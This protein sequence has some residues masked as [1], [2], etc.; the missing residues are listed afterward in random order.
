MADQVTAGDFNQRQM[1]NP[2]GFLYLVGTLDAGGY[3]VF[4]FS[5]DDPGHAVVA[6]EPHADEAA[7]VAEADRLRREALN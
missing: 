3:A 7:A 1:W 5:Q 6:S 4:R 2:R